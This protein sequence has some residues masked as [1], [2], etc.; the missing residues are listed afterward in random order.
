MTEW[1]V[2]YTKCCRVWPVV[3]EGR[4]GIC[5]ALIDTPATAEEIIGYLEG[6]VKDLASGR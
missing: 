6:R 4:C 3:Q 2:Y 1:F 5:G